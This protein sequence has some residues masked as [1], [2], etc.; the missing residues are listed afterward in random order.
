MLVRADDGGVHRGLVGDVELQRAGPRRRTA[1]SSGASV[2][3]S[4]AVAA[5]RSPRSSAASAQMRPKPFDVPVMNQT[6]AM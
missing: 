5:T 4:R 6:F 2:V 1:R 3:A